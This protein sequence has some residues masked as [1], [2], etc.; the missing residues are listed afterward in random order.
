MFSLQSFIVRVNH[1]CIALL[2]LQS[3]PYCNTI[4]RPLRNIRPPPPT[5]HPPFDAMHH[6]ILVVAIAAV[7][8]G[9]GGV[10]WE[11]KH[12]IIIIIG[13]YLPK[14]G[15]GGGLRFW[16]LHDIAIPNIVC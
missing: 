6:T 12:I 10:P 1:P 13:D 8:G 3:L 14:R 5:P 2:N 7:L 9:G 16:P 11:G 4:A 15:R